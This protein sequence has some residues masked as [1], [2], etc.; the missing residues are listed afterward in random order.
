MTHRARHNEVSEVV[1]RRLESLLAD[2]PPRRA[3]AEPPVNLV[4]SAPPAAEL[5][6]VEAPPEAG[7]TRHSLIALVQGR[8]W[9]FVREHLVVVGII[10]LAGCLWAGYS[11]FAA[12]TTTVAVAAPTASV[13]VNT[14]AASP[15]PTAALL[16]HV[17]GEVR[18][19]GVVSLPVGARVQD[20]ISAAGG[21]TT[22][23]RPGQLNLAERVTD[24]AQIVIGRNDSQVR[25]ASAQPG[26]TVAAVIDL[27][28]A[29]ADQLDALPGVGPVTAQKILAWREQNGRFRTVA[30]L[31]EVDGIGPKSYAEIAPRVRV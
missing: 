2:I 8:A 16:V 10:V 23:A 4:D 14:P 28:T 6:P 13:E 11:L 20:A 26:S 7:P 15:T 12:R 3:S 5:P 1:R 25:G 30:E 21:L 22:K 31:Q 24:G 27:N 19:P 29:T 9:T 17:L 18:R